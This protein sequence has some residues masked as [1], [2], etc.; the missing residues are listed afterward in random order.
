MW[1]V[2]VSL[3]VGKMLGP[4]CV[5]ENR[6]FALREPVVQKPS[7]Y[8]GEHMYTLPLMRPPPAATWNDTLIVAWF[9]CEG[10]PYHMMHETLGPISH[11]MQLHGLTSAA[12][13]IVGKAQWP[14][15]AA[16]GCHSTRFSPLLGVL[17]VYFAAD[18]CYRRAIQ[19]TPDT[20]G[21]MPNQLLDW[22][23]PQQCNQN[24]VVIVQRKSSRRIGNIDTLRKIALEYTPDVR[25]VTLEDMPLREQ[26]KAL[27]CGIVA[28]VHGAGLAWAQL[29][30]AT[31]KAA[32]LIEWTWHK[33][34]SFYVARCR[35]NLV[36]AIESKIP[37][38]NT[39]CPN[40]AACAGDRDYPTKHFDVNVTEVSWRKDLDAATLH[41]RAMVT[42]SS[43]PSRAQVWRRPLRLL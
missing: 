42:S 10:N 14:P 32:A 35:S 6:G 34:N 1:A 41:V 29:L 19:V 8:G 25:I 40:A 7:D 30:K 22:A 24:R 11:T 16:S 26:I 43:S 37:L 33:W 18:T 23:G 17:G 4:V 2:V 21:T 20:V 3:V 15:P 5:I 31:G 12:V 38:A 13:I 39:W 36:L 9:T 27:S 28:G